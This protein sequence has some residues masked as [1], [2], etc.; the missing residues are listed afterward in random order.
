MTVQ[1]IELVAG[2][3]VQWRSGAR[4]QLQ[5]ETGLGRLELLE[6]INDEPRLTVE[7]LAPGADRVLPPGAWLT[8]VAQQGCRVVIRR[9][10]SVG[11]W[12]LLAQWLGTHSRWRSGPG[13]A[14]SPA[15]RR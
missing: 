4:E 14:V 5:V 3:R 9:R 15:A 6:W 11:W 8:L 1:T 10:E 13:G 7:Q 12:R 2:Q